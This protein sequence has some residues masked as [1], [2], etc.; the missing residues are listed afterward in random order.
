MS[1]LEVGR[2]KSILRRVRASLRCRVVILMYHRVFK[3]SSDPWGLCVSP[4]HFAEQLEHLRRHYSLLS[5]HK[6]VSSLRDARLPKRGVVLTFD[7]GY[8]DNLWNVKPILEKY[9]VPATFFVTS[10]SVDSPSEFW[11]DDLERVM[12]KPRKLPKSLQLRVKDQSY[13]WLTTNL[14]ER[15][16]AYMAIHQI[17][18]AL[19]VSD[20]DQLMTDL[21]A[22]AE[23]EP[24]GRRDYR[25]LTTAELIQLA[26]SELVDI[27]AHTITH[28]SLPLISQT[29]Q[30]NEIAGSRQ[31]LEGILRSRVNS[32]SYPYGNFTPETI[33][34]VKTAGFEVAL[35]IETNV[36]EVG[37][38][39]FQLGRLA[40]SDWGGEEFEQQMHEFFRI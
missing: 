39:Q 4:R 26:Q 16:R 18:Q 6:L 2:L 37:A 35:T 1:L 14:D 24:V 32:F 15:H 34:I 31:R 20:R 3:T 10:G 5:L 13:E 40:V 17:L 8:A 33:D 12:L 19:S 22:W 25:P 29:D 38:N 9:E 7:D 30:Y 23:V 11:W 21:F 36:V 27:G 28:P